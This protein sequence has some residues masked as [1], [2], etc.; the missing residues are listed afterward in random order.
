MAGGQ[1]GLHTGDDVP[2]DLRRRRRIPWT[3]LI[4]A[5]L[6]EVVAPFVGV[7]SL[8][9]EQRPSASSALWLGHGSAAA[10]CRWRRGTQGEAEE[11]QCD[12][13]EPPVAS[14][15]PGERRPRQIADGGAAEPGSYGGG[16]LQHRA[17]AGRRSSRGR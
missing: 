13:A 1:L 5:K 17:A 9:I 3:R 14:A 7:P 10:L 11:V 12:V 4:D 6:V 15:C 2:V 8:R 16:V